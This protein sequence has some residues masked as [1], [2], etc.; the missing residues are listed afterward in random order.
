M[1]TVCIVQARM[2]STR[3]PG[4]VLQPILHRPM[5]CWVINRVKRCRL[6]DD[7][8]IATTTATQEDPIVDF[9]TSQ[10]WSFCRGSEA[11]VLDRYYRAAQ[12]FGAD[13]VVRITSDCPLIDRDVT[14]NVIATY[15]SVMPAP[16]YVS[17]VL[18]RT[19]PRGLDT[20]VLSYAALS[21][22]WSEDQSMRWREH[23][24]PYI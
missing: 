17:N 5:L 23:V 13:H 12:Q 1:K 3:L 22:A 6:I 18:I 14:D 10:G 11:D 8:V 19:Y 21:R 7:V 15:H 4:K 24:T 2:G 9:C 16:D 20:E